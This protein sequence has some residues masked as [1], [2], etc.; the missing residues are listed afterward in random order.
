MLAQQGMHNIAQTF[1]YFQVWFQNRR[2]KWR[3]SER[4]QVPATGSESATGDKQMDDTG[5][6]VSCGGPELSIDVVS[7][8]SDRC[9]NGHCC[10]NGTSPNDD[11]IVDI[12]HHS[13][14]P[15]F[16]DAIRS[17]YAEG[18]KTKPEVGTISFESA[19]R[20]RSS[21]DARQTGSCSPLSDSQSSIVD[22]F[23][24]YN[25]STAVSGRQF[26]VS[27]SSSNFDSDIHSAATSRN[28][29]NLLSSTSSVFVPATHG[30]RDTTSS[31]LLAE[32]CET[33]S[34]M[35]RSLQHD[36]T[37]VGQLDSLL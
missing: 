4:F 26:P 16:E 23:P 3:K 12:A 33:M 17:S 36:Q 31:S 5:S 6:D 37:T 2:A 35:R 9:L 10:G 28:N 18:F 25:H 15:K 22:R 30:S 34:R 14:S 32:V 7:S 21:D 24:V 8:E 1:N 27:V 19:R 29:F 13:Q 11:V 20:F